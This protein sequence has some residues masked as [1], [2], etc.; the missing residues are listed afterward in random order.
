MS[1]EVRRVPVDFNWPLNKPW[2]GYFSPPR[3]HTDTCP[4]CD[5]TGYSDHARTLQDR[6]YGNVPFDPSETGSEPLTMFTAEVRA[7][8]Q[9]NVDYAPDLHGTGPDAVDREA[10]RLADY[11][12]SA[13]L[14]HLDQDDVDAL[15][16]EGGLMELTHTF[17]PGE[18]WKPIEPTPT[19]TA[20]QVNR[21]AIGGYG[22]DGYNCSIVV[23]AACKRAGKPVTCS[24]CDGQG[25]LEVYPGQRAEAAAWKPTE[26]PTGD[27]WQLW[28]TVSEGSP[29]SPAFA[30]ADDLATWMSDPVR[31]R[32]WLPPNVAQAF[33]QQGW[34]PTG[35]DT[36]ETGMVSGVEWVG[37]QDWRS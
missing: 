6:W 2:K 26:P 20:E 27:G 4:T 17:R 21:W 5:G 8:A 35:I 28:E 11:W 23:R 1:R 33:I 12:N 13:W 7:F 30:T 15:L 31:G 16:A 36:Q 32:D 19:V 22:H 29:I 9:R 14:H 3:L 24:Y 10:Q 37:T 18:G 25:S 34:A